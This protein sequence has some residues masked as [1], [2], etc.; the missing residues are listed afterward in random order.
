MELFYKSYIEPVLYF[1]ISCWFGNLSVKYKNALNRIATL[2]R[3]IICKEQ[4]NLSSLFNR[5]VLGW[6][7][8][9]LLDRDHFLYSEFFMLPTGSRYRLPKMKSYQYKLFV[10][11][12]P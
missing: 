7:Q 5:N 1:A 8:S 9:V 4:R 6:A 10:P 11:Y 12:G 2:S 3:K